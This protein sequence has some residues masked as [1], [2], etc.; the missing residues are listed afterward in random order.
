[1]E[2][3]FNRNKELGRLPSIYQEM[4]ELDF[5]DAFD[6]SPRPYGY[7]GSCL[8]ILDPTEV[9]RQV[10]ISVGN[11]PFE[12]MRKNLGNLFETRVQF[13]WDIFPPPAGTIIER[14]VT[15]F[16]TLEKHVIYT[17]TSYHTVRYPI[18]TPDDVRA[19]KYIL[20]GR[21]YSFNLDRFR[22]VDALIG[23]RAAP[24]LDFPRTNI[25]RLNIE[26]M[27][28]ENTMYAL[29]DQ[30]ELM[31]ELIQVINLTD[32][33]ILQ[34][35]AKS[36]IPIIDF[37]DNIDQHLV[38]PTLFKRYIIPA[39]Q[40]RVDYLHA[41]HKVCYSHWD[42]MCPLL[43]K[44]IPDTH[45]DGIEALTP[46]PM[47]VLTIDEI[48]AAL[49]ENLIFLDGIPMTSFLPYTRDEDLEL[50]TRQLIETFAP[51]LILGISDEPSP[52][53][54]IEKIGLV[55]KI[56]KEYEGKVM[57]LPNHRHDTRPI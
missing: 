48:K 11:S 22:E 51:N 36:P 53:C 24:M 28:F 38:S 50:I 26:L 2:Y 19:M 16:G 17:N 12:P 9:K 32:D 21:T 37:G 5:F 42:G 55:A 31:E 46:Q 10:F 7:Y 14:G 15:P 33:G 47:G 8:E 35:V 43:L 13:T 6:C 34:V 20:E 41:D 49:G 52:D 1:M 57:D 45:L 3:L 18:E 4:G 40:H 27:G 30:P 56:V 54:S 23:P 39:Y 44:F 25:Q 29:H